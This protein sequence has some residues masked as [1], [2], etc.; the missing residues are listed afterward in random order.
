MVASI[1]T[2]ALAAMTE[3]TTRGREVLEGADMGKP[4]F[5]VGKPGIVRRE[6]NFCWRENSGDWSMCLLGMHKAAS[7]HQKREDSF[8]SGGF[9][10]APVIRVWS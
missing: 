9:S 3:A 6:E 4:E 1:A 8:L 10:L 5:A 7:S 2:I